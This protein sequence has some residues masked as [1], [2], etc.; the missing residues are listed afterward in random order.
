MDLKTYF[1]NDITELL[2]WNK[3]YFHKVLRSL[4]DENGNNLWLNMPEKNRMLDDNW[5]YFQTL[6]QN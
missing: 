6:T 3:K 4:D 1:L 5:N 2:Y